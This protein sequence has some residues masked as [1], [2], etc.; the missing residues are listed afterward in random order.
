MLLVA[1]ITPPTQIAISASV[2]TNAVFYT[3][4]DGRVFNGYITPAA[5][6]NGVQ[7]SAGAAGLYSFSTSNTT[8]PPITLVGG[9]VLTGINSVVEL[10]GVESDA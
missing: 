10:I 9:T 8:R 2:A 3:V 7:L 4:P 6:I 5:K 1:S